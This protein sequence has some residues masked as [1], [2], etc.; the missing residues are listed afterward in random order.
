MQAIANRLSLVKTHLPSTLETISFP[1]YASAS[2]V[3]STTLMPK[4][5]DQ[6]LLSE[7]PMVAE[8]AALRKASLTSLRVSRQKAM[9]QILR[10]SREPRANVYA[11]KR[12]NADGALILV[13]SQSK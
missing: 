8:Y 6:K 3:H 9:S 2:K 7:N 5:I 11:S 1:F 4:Q 10:Y 12:V 13:D